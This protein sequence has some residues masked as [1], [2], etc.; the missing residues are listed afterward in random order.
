MATRNGGRRGRA[1]LP[2]ADARRTVVARLRQEEDRAYPTLDLTGMRLRDLILRDM[3]GI[4]ADFEEFARTHTGAGAAMDVT[5]LRDHAEDM[6]RGF[7]VDMDSTQTDRQQ[8][9]KSEG[10][11]PALSGGRMSAATQHG[12]DRAGSGFTLQE[13]FAEYRALRA[14]VL[15]HWTSQSGS[16]NDESVLDM[17]RFNEA[18]DQAVAESITR[19]SEALNENRDMFLGVLGHDLRTPLSAVLTAAGYLTGEE[20]LDERS[21]T[22]A[23][24]VVRSGTRMTELVDDL[25]DFTL[26]RLGR[27]IP[28]ERAPVDMA[29]IVRDTVDELRLINAD[30]EFRMECVGDLA[31][32][33]DRRRV[34][35]VVSNLVLNAVQHGASTSAITIVARPEDDHVVVAVRNRGA[36]IGDAD[37]ADIFEPFTRRGTQ[38]IGHREGRSIG[39]GLY[40][41]QQVALAHGGLIDVDSSSERGTTFTLRL[42]RHA[43]AEA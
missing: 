9:V 11:G 12:H 13:M 29:A 23:Q 28:V 5:A 14:S 30:R 15:R 22:L 19:Y 41:A 1:T 26:A 8:R 33:W 42:P 40:I 3:E 24:T 7:V 20:C 10:D 38:Q 16:S 18:I 39:L 37:L 31:G 34:T 25:L 35:Q 6:L 2:G 36:T 17:I 27:G 32:E 4:L 21:R 43:P